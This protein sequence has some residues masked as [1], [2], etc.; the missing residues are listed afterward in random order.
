MLF[1]YRTNALSLLYT[2]QGQPFSL[3]KGAR[4]FFDAEA[5]ALIPKIYFLK[6]SKYMAALNL[7]ICSLL[8]FPG[9]SGWFSSKVLFSK[10]SAQSCCYKTSIST[11]T[12][13]LWICILKH[14]WKTGDL[15][16]RNHLMRQWAHTHDLISIDLFCWFLWK[17]FWRKWI[18]YIYIYIYMCV[19]LIVM[20][21]HV[22]C[23]STSA[24]RKKHSEK[25]KK[26]INWLSPEA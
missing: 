5:F 1:C 2:T 11:P 3:L 9:S 10:F 6:G 18:H 17:K 7:K 8:I 14:K 24:K 22:V 21:Q 20:I 25:Q 13:K 4:T 16:S 12:I 26:I 23:S 19:C 15:T